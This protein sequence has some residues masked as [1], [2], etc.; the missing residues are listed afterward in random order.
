VKGYSA[1]WSQSV[2]ILPRNKTPDGSEEARE[3]A[4]FTGLVLISLAP[5]QQQ[6]HSAGMGSPLV[7]V[8]GLD[9]WIFVVILKIWGLL[10]T[11]CGATS[12]IP[13]TVRASHAQTSHL[14]SVWPFL[15]PWQPLLAMSHLNT[16]GEFLV[17]LTQPLYRPILKVLPGY[18][19]LRYGE[20]KIKWISSL[21]Q[22]WPL[23]Q[24]ESLVHEIP[25]W[26]EDLLAL[27]TCPASRTASLSPALPGWL[28]L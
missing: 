17:S 9:H 1:W 3:I 15:S 26:I 14:V 16:V 6:P 23:K 19:S 21:H 10:P 12:P 22:C 7:M 20:Y 4:W 5:T 27:L 11:E 28:W 2:Q 13:F 24:E 25:H 8:S 18:R